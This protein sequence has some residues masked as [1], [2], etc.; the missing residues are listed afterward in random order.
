MIIKNDN[1]SDRDD[2]L[3]TLDKRGG[4]FFKFYENGFLL[5]YGRINEYFFESSFFESKNRNSVSIN[6]I[7]QNYII[8]YINSFDY[9]EGEINFDATAQTIDGENDTYIIFILTHKLS[10]EKFNALNINNIYD[11]Y[12]EQIIQHEINHHR[13]KD[14]LNDFKGVTN[15]FV[16][17]VLADTLLILENSS[18]DEFTNIKK[19]DIESLLQQLK[20]GYYK[21]YL[22]VVK[23]I[24]NSNNPILTSKIV[25]KAIRENGIKD[26]NINS[27]KKRLLNEISTANNNSNAM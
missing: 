26:K 8:V 19:V 14:L 27:I 4:T 20:I 13:T 11:K 1:M 18:N 21:D 25:L 5:R 6:G 10:T 24:I 17:E 7:S 3:E 12:L 9:V 2:F 22:D 23:E 15:Q 16:S